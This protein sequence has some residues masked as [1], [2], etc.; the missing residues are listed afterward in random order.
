MV[1]RV[2]DEGIDLATKPV[3]TREFL[4][5]DDPERYKGP[6][7]QVGVGW[8]DRPNGTFDHEGA[9]PYE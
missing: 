1:D 6:S 3:V 9:D 8:Y 4:A 5:L 7:V 2:D